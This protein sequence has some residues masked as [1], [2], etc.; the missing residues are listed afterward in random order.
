MQNFINKECHEK[1]LMLANVQEMEFPIRGDARGRLARGFL[2]KVWFGMCEFS[3]D[4]IIQV[5]AF[6]T[7]P[8]CV[9]INTWPNK[10][11][12]GYSLRMQL[13]D[14]LPAAV[15]SA[16]MGCAVWSVGCM[17]EPQSILAR[18]GLVALQG[19]AGVVVYFFVVYL[20]RL[21]VVCEILMIVRTHCPERGI[22]LVDCV[23]HRFVR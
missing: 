8:L 2:L 16:I 3:K 5:P 10:K 6:V 1:N 9:I 22:R 4:A 17:A 14:I 12:F 13:R 18:F 7:S 20:F 11:L 19:V 15:A 21:S 23:L